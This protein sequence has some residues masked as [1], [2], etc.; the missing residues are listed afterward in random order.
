MLVLLAQA[1]HDY[2]AHLACGVLREHGVEA[3]ILHENSG[4]LHGGASTTTASLWVHDDDWQ[5]A[6]EIL[7]TAPIEPLP[8][9]SA[10]LMNIPREL[11]PP[12]GA[13]AVGM[14][15][16]VFAASA[17]ATL[18]AVVPQLGKQGLPAAVD[19]ALAFLLSLLGNAVTAMGFGL[20]TGLLSAVLFPV[21][22]MLR[23]GSRIGTIL[24]KIAGVIIGFM[25]TIGLA[26]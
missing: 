7:A 26:F 2:R 3:H 11:F 12:A 9:G 1:T 8:E 14:A 24:M 21:L 16:V 20:A 22:R 18:F 10:E 25:I 19:V 4:I 13:V 5:D 6:C 15:T 23:R 17:T